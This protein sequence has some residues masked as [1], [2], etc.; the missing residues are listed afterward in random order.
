MSYLIIGLLLVV[1]IFSAPMP[2]ST[3]TN[4]EPPMDGTDVFDKNIV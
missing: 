3:N 2:S 4:D 1:V